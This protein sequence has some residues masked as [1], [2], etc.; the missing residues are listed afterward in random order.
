MNSKLLALLAILHP[1]KC[2]ALNAMEETRREVTQSPLGGN[3]ASAS[4]KMAVALR[5]K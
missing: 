5:A 2:K 4:A 3:K 1:A